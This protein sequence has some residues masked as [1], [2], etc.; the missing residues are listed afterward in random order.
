[1]LAPEDTIVPVITLKKNIN[2]GKDKVREEEG[3]GKHKQDGDT[4]GELSED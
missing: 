4:G 2:Y 3:E 1:M